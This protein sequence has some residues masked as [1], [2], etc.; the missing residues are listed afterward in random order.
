MRGLFACRPGGNEAG[1]A[2]GCTSDNCLRLLSE[3]SPEHQ[4]VDDIK[5]EDNCHSLAARRVVPRTDSALYV[6]V[7]D[8]TDFGGDRAAAREC[9]RRPQAASYGA[10]QHARTDAAWTP[11]G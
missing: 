8:F 7:T 5:R 6:Q 9:E 11:F 4:R 1:A 2:R 3:R 10:A